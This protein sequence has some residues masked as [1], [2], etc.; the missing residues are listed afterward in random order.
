M[1]I[2]HAECLAL[3]IPFYADHVVHDRD[4]NGARNLLAESSP[5]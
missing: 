5:T 3:D 4:V 2:V 1:K